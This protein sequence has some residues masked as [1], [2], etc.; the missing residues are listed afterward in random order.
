MAEKLLGAHDSW[1]Y[2]RPTKWWMRLI[3]FTS[4]CQ[5]VDIYEQYEKYGITIFDIRIR[6][7]GEIPHI[8][9]GIIDFGEVSW[10]ELKFLSDH[11][12]SMRVMLEMNFPLRDQEHQEELFVEFCKKL[13]EEYPG[14]YLFGGSRKFDGKSIYSFGNPGL[15]LTD[16]YSSVTSLFK[17]S[18]RALAVIDDLCPILYA[19][20]K[21]KKNYQRYISGEDYEGKYFFYDFV[22]IR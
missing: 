20:L 7:H 10:D 6:F 5:E 16:A 14:I 1:S 19:H 9:H 4:K 3:H 13:Q 8:H 12:C 2:R 15:P 17:S 11:K 18:S 21:N 22:N